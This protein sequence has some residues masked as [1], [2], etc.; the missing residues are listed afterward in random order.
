MID[1]KIYDSKKDPRNKTSFTPEML[2]NNYHKDE[3][4]A[5]KISFVETPDIQMQCGCVIADYQGWFGL[6]QLVLFV[7]NPFR[8]SSHLF[9]CYQ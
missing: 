5:T 2:Q 7:Q 8:M 3:L 4:T 9:M 6:A 1:I